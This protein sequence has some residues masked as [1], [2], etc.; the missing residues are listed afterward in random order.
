M[1]TNHSPKDLSEK[2]NAYIRKS[3]VSRMDLD[4]CR[5]IVTG[6]LLSTMLNVRANVHR[7]DLCATAMS[8]VPHQVLLTSDDPLAILKV[9]TDVLERQLSRQL[10]VVSPEELLERA[11]KQWLANFPNTKIMTSYSEL[12]DDDNHLLRF[13]IVDEDTKT[14]FLSLDHAQC[15]KICEKAGVSLELYIQFQIQTEVFN[16]WF[17]NAE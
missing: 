3:L 9:T 6:D 7:G 17:N 5:V 10:D 13:R 8:Q 4:Y 2:V 1:T 16:K 11:E 12:D 14:I 15:V